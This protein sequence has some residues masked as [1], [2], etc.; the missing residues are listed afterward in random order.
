M[1]EI[2]SIEDVFNF[3]SFDER[4]KDIA[5]RVVMRRKELGITQEELSSKAGVSYGSIKRF[6]TKGEISLKHLL[7]IAIAL[8]CENDFEELFKKRNYKSIQEVI[9]ERKNK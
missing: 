8:D 6:E 3:K 9:D 1:K 4:A 5:K 2:Y 7:K